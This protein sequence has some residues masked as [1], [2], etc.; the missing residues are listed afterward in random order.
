MLRRLLIVLFLLPGLCL[1]LQA[2]KKVKEYVPFDRGIDAPPTV[3]IPKGTSSGGLTFS[4]LSYKIGDTSA[5]DIGYSLVPSLVTGVK[6][7]IY[8]F[9]IAPSY[10]YFLW[11]NNSIG[12]NFGY[13]RASFGLG[14]L[15]LNIGE[16]LSFGV[17]DFYYIS[18]TFSGA[19]FFRNY[20]PLAQ[21]KRFAIL[22]E[23]RLSG[24]YGQTKGYKIEDGLKHGTYTDVYKV[25]INFVPGLCVFATNAMAV[26]A[27]MSVL[28]LTYRNVKQKE[29]QVNQS[30]YHGANTSFGL[31]VLS[32]E[33]GM[34]IYILDKRHRPQKKAQAT[35]VQTPEES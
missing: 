28:G 5:D 10:E 12:A 4:L 26:T 9:K 27:Q 35:T 33:V 19:V 34:S 24:S 22:L 7:S 29:N 13:S 2:Q 21:S 8:R 25:G 3:F 16:D 31:D 23:G 14:N 1:V 6:G 15:D 20:L 32:V 11:D 17:D 18:N 30:G